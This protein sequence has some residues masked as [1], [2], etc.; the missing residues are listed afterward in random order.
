V[1]F[2]F[3]LVRVASGSIEQ[4]F[5]RTD[6]LRLTVIPAAIHLGGRIRV[7]LETPN[8]EGVG[9]GPQWWIEAK[10]GSGWVK[11]PF[12][13]GGPWYEIEYE[14]GPDGSANLGSIRIPSDAHPGRY[15]VK[16]VLDLAHRHRRPIFAEFRVTN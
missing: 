11:A 15:R 5:G 10:S 14:L 13:P 1:A 6:E 7:R 8:S 3:C 2:A 4:A 12:S 16:K 9:F